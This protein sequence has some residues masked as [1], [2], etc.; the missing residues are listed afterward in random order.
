MMNSIEELQVALKSYVKTMPNLGIKLGV[1][2][3]CL[4][5]SPDGT[6]SSEN[7]YKDLGSALTNPY[8]TTD[9][10]ENLLELITA[11]K[12]SITSLIEELSAIHSFTASNIGDEFLWCSSMPSKILSD[13]EIS[14]AKFG[15]SNIGQLKSLYRLGLKKRYSSTM[16]IISGIHFNFSVGDK[17]LA[18]IKELKGIEHHFS[19]FKSDSYLGLARNIQRYGWLTTYLYGASPFVDQSFLDARGLKTELIPFDDKGTMYSPG[20]CS[21]RMSN[22]GYQNS[23]Q[24][25]IAL[26]YN[27][28]G[29]YT[30]SL[31]EAVK[32]PH[33]QWEEIGL[34]DS[35]GKRQQLNTNLIQ[36][37]NEFYN[38]I[39]PKRTILP[40][41]RPTEALHDRGVEYIEYRAVDIN[42]FDPIGLSRGQI[43]FFTTFLLYNMIMESPESTEE[44]FKNSRNNIGIVAMS[45]RSADT[46]IHHR[47]EL[48]PLKDAG[49]QLLE[50]MLPVA[51]I[52][53]CASGTTNYSATIKAETEKMRD[54]A[55]TL[56]GKMEQILRSKNISY[57][58]FMT[59]QSKKHTEE[60]K[61][62][63]IS[64]RLQGK[65]NAEAISSLVKQNEIEG[66]DKINFEQYLNQYLNA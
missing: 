62:Y 32:T 4:R 26:L 48:I 11:P 18:V 42:P 5:L 24:G 2:R 56:S 52:L 60:L 51:E 38:Q 43:E 1:E 36:I 7:H 49:L 44:D 59:E 28:I 57:L 54:P 50:E 55:L 6:L 21:L 15:T 10:A 63:E 41:E 66:L 3:E 16:Q 35:D 8:I 47:G 61:R 27:T 58:E 39:R 19:Q 12:D 45:G 40:G 33:P 65:L 14:I 25:E 29:S 13:D 9:Y 34:L 37:E 22:F 53:D 46:Q 30:S 23:T 31:L 17:L 64:E 20:A